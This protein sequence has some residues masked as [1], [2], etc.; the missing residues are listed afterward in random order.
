[1]KNSL[2]SPELRKRLSM[3]MLTIAPVIPLLLMI[4]LVARHGVDIPFAD[5]WTLAPLFVKAHEHTVTFMDIFK[6]WHEHRM[7]LPK[8]IFIACS[9]WAGGNMRMEMFLS[10]ILAAGSAINLFLILRRSSL[11]PAKLLLVATLMNLLLFSPV[12][13]ESWTWGVQVTVFLVNYL[14]TTGICI[15][16]SSLSIGKKFVAC[17]M[18]AFLTSFSFGNGMLSLGLTFPVVFVGLDRSAR[19]RLFPW[20]AGWILIALLTIG[21]YFIGYTKTPEHPA[22]AASRH[23]TDYF[24]YVA[25]FVGAPL[26]RSGRAE[27][28]II[29]LLLG[30]LLL[31]VYASAV[32]YAFAGRRIEAQKLLAPWFALGAFALLSACMAALG[33]VGFGLTEA[34]ASRSTTFGLLLSV[35]VVAIVAIG[36]PLV[37]SDTG[38]QSGLI[39]AV[40]RTEAAALALFSA[41]FLTSAVWGILEMKSF[42]RTRLWGKGA[43]HFGN[44][45]DTSRVVSTFLGGNA[46]DVMRFAWMDN[47]MG[48]LHPALAKSR[49]LRDL[50]AVRT[51]QT[52]IGFIHH[53]GTMVAGSCVV[54]GWAVLPSKSRVADCVVLTLHAGEPGAE[55]AFVV[56]DELEDR[57]D[58]AKKLGC[59]NLVRCGWRARFDRSKIPAGE[60]RIGAWALDANSGTLYKLGGTLVL[61]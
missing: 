10:V 21:A 26:S 31:I 46:A 2:P 28:L 15:A 52:P 7:V 5:E 19:R 59:P 30:T 6:H 12:Q 22:F 16:S 36:A 9:V 60:Q 18:I 1:M 58:V 50:P 40:G 41:M 54:S 17:A 61:R 34:L 37:R 42:E 38:S 32:A 56:N 43:L 51:A 57:P 27:S 55:Y 45:F 14:L 3:V 13:A 8:L 23:V 35:A 25:A 24:L 53:Q 39:D 20:L 29:P 44:V 4:H 48:L 47:S 49:Y 11:P 33:R